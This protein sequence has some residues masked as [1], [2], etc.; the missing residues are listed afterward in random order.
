M[1]TTHRGVL[2]HLRVPKTRRTKRTPRRPGRLGRTTASAELYTTL[3][4]IGLSKRVKRVDE[5]A[6]EFDADCIMGHRKVDGHY[7]FL[8]RWKGY[9]S[10]ADT[11]E[12]LGNFL[13]RYPSDLVKDA[14]THGLGNLAVMKYLQSEPDEVV[15][16]QVARRPLVFFCL[17]RGSAGREVTTGLNRETESP[18]G[19]VYGAT[20]PASR[21]HS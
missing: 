16:L 14:K 1:Y 20:R 21:Q 17:V 4:Y 2:G 19:R 7:E 3:S 13:D 10:E 5:P 8:T 18:R 9:R 15:V 11:W 12:T 6:P